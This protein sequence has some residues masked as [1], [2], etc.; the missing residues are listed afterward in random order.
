[1][2]LSNGRLITLHMGDGAFR[3][4][5]RRHCVPVLNWL[6]G[7]KDGVTLHELDYGVVKS[8]ASATII[9]GALMKAGWVSRDDLKRFH[10]TNEG[11]AALELTNS[12]EAKVLLPPEEK[13]GRGT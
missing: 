12:K 6:A 2:K 3:L 4:L 1:M 13:K 11:R 9:T 5:G 7:S 10:L 8:H